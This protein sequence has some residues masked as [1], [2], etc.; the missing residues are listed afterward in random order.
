MVFDAVRRPVAR[1]DALGRTA[2]TVFDAAGRAIAAIDSGGFRSSTSYHAAGRQQALTSARGYV[3]TTI[4]DAASRRQATLNARGDRTTT[5]F[6]AANQPVARIDGNGHRTTLAYDPVARR[7]SRTDALGRVRTWEFDSV[8]NVIRSQDA[9]AQVATMSYSARNEQTE[10]GYADGTRVTRTYDAREQMTVARDSS[11]I[12]TQTWDA[13]GKLATVVAPSH[14]NGAPITYGFDGRGLRTQMALGTARH[15]WA[16]DVAARNTAYTDPDGGRATWSYSG[17]NEMTEQVNWNGTATTWTYESRGLTSGIR[18][19]KSDGSEL[20]VDLYGY[21]AN[22]NPVTKVTMGGRNTWG[23]DSLDQLTSEQHEIG[24]V[25]TWTYDAVGNRL[26]QDRTQG[27]VRTLTN[28]T[29]D[30]ADELTLITEGTAVTTVTFDGNGNQVGEQ[31]AAGRVT[32]QWN[33]RDLMTGYAQSDGKMATFTHRYDDLRASM[34]P[35]DGSAATKL[36]WDPLGTTGYV[37]LLAETAGDQ[38]VPRQ[39]WRGVRLVSYKEAGQKGAYEFDHLGNTE[40]VVSVAQAVLV[41]YQISAWGEALATTGSLGGQRFQFGGE[42]GAYR[43]TL[44][45]NLWMRGRVMNPLLGRF[46]SVDP[47]A[48]RANRYAYCDLAPLRLIDPTGYE[49]E[50]NIPKTPPKDC[51]ELCAQIR[52]SNVPF[53]TTGGGG[54]FCYA[55]KLKCACVLP[56]ISVYVSPGQCPALDLCVIVHELQHFG[57]CGCDP[58]YGLQR[59]DP[60][61]SDAARLA[62]ECSLRRQSIACLATISVGTTGIL[63]QA[64]LVESIANL[65]DWVNANC[66]GV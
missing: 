15:T 47:L 18:H 53:W 50:P 41:A 34:D 52:A 1:L 61:I 17:A 22:A 30:A 58:K 26:S 56:D 9:K 27:G 44:F 65:W 42:W 64:A 38:S 51:D 14:P 57:S 59:A 62:E 36:V 63:C 25:S 40:R 39:Y 24:L 49:A 60:T 66:G 45:T 43:D 3:T 31:S 6:D 4:F 8:G 46:L 55:D 2:T 32:Y 28:Y 37:D 54:V 19:R 29:A 21:D 20:G 7:V 12:T 35:G 11:G 16:F 13:R 5:V 23:Y 48:L 10:A 33:P